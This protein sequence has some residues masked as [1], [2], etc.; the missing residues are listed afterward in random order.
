MDHLGGDTNT[1]PSPHS[2]REAGSA[3]PKHCSRFCHKYLETLAASDALFAEVGVEGLGSAMV[4]SLN[5]SERHRLCHGIHRFAGDA[6]SVQSA[7]LRTSTKDARRSVLRLMPTSQLD[8]PF[9]G[10]FLSDQ[11]VHKPSP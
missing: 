1:V 8:H 10:K 11:H 6:T 4:H 7:R 9:R 3:P 5:R 2:I